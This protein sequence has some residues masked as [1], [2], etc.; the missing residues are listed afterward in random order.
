MR[1]YVLSFLL[2]VSSL[3]V[4]SAAAPTDCVRLYT[5]SFADG[6]QIILGTGRSLAA[7]AALYVS[8]D[9]ALQAIVILTPSEC[10]IDFKP[11]PPLCEREPE[12]ESVELLP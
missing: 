12:P 5:A 10:Q 2:L 8:E 9:L 4:S 7:G 11:C 3:G 6:N 1:A